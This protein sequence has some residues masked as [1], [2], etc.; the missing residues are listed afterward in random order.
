MGLFSFG[1]RSSGASHSS[2]SSSS[3]HSSGSHANL[4]F[5]K[6]HK[7]IIDAHEMKRA[8]SELKESLHS[9]YRAKQVEDRLVGYTDVDHKAGYH[10]R[11]GIDRSE[12][13]HFMQEGL[14]DFSK[15]EK[16]AVETTLNRY[17]KN[18]GNSRFFKQ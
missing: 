16:A 18:E 17:L 1:P 10:D 3:S 11:A 12:V 9:K 15:T 4:G 5:G 6:Q 8:A 2:S 14:K 7:E 13:E